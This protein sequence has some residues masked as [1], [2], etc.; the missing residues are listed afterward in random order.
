MTIDLVCWF[1]AAGGQV[2]R[3]RPDSGCLEPLSAI[4]EG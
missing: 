2:I 1:S 3:Y 4:L